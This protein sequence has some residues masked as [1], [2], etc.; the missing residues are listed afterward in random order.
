MTSIVSYRGLWTVRGREIQQQIEQRIWKTNNQKSFVEIIFQVTH[1]FN[2]WEF[3]FSLPIT[4]SGSDFNP[5]GSCPWRTSSNAESALVHKTGSTDLLSLISVKTL[6]SPMPTICKNKQKNQRAFRI[7][8]KNSLLGW[9]LFCS[10]MRR[11]KQT[12][13]W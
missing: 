13:L 3:H 9:E 10:V 4:S 6:L 11:V 1:Q 8:L 12:N 5:S 2:R 7:N